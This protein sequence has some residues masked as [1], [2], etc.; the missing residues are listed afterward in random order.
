MQKIRKA[1]IPAAGLGTRF[2]PATKAMAKEMMPIVDTPSIQYVVEEAIAS[3]IEEI[4]IVSGKGK[5]SIE[6]HFD[7]NFTLEENLR[8]NGK[9]EMLTILQKTNIPSIHYV[10]QPYPKGL[11]DAILQ[12]APFVGDE[13][14]VV[15]LGDDIMPNDIPLTK[16]LMD[17]YEKTEGGVVATM[18][19]PNNLVNRYGIIDI[20]D[21]VSE[22]V[23]SVDHFIEKPNLEDAPSNLAIIGRY[24]LTPEIFDVLRS[25]KPDSGNEVQLTD[26]IEALNQ[27]HPLTAFEYTG[28]RCDVGDK[29]GLL[30]ANI[31]F[32]LKKPETAKKMHDYIIALSKE[33]KK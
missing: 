27:I 10:R 31:E 16:L 28:K 7:V 30:I 2:L 13:P 1:V 8:K 26:A 32:G 25:Q 12:A 21:Q 9:N 3:G 22:H 6:D 5:S 19:I 33:L 18:R 14:F 20:Q 23:Y 24:L 15:L 11:G 4:I 17:T 29:Y